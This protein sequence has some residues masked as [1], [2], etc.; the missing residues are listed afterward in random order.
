VDSSADTPWLPPPPSSARRGVRWLPGCL[1]VVVAIPWAI[2][3]SG[4]TLRLWSGAASDCEVF[5]AGNR[6]AVAILFWPAMSIVLWAVVTTF[7][8]LFSRRSI[9]LGLGVGVAVTLTLAYLYLAGTA[10]MIL[11]EGGGMFCPTGLPDWWPWWAPR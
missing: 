4:A 3:L 7:V 1:A 10:D 2:V 9:L 5:E 6:F 8:V 11:A